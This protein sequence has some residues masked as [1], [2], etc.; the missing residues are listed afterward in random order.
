MRQSRG[1]SAAAML[2]V[3]LFGLPAAVSAQDVEGSR[4]HPL[5]NR[6]PD[7]FIDDYREKDFDVYDGFVDSDGSYKA[8]EGH[9]YYTDYHFKEGTKPLTEGFIIRNYREALKKIGGV[10]LYEDAYNAYMRLDKGGKMTWVHVHPWNGGQG[11]ALTIVEEAP[12]ERVVVADAAALFQEINATG[13]VAVCGIYFDTGKTL[14]KP[15]RPSPRGDRQA[16]RRP[17]R[18]QALSGRPHGQRGALDYNMNLSQKR[19]EAVVEVLV[20]RYSIA[21]A[22]WKPT[23]WAR[24]CRPPRTAPRMA[25]P[26]TGGSSWWSDEAA[27]HRSPC[28][29]YKVDRRQQPLVAGLQRDSWQALVFEVHR[30]A[31]LRPLTIRRR[32]PFA[33]E[34]NERPPGRRRPHPGSP[35]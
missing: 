3:L 29:A 15:D 9:K 26:R 16:P 6:L 27:D 24:C 10:V 19:A 31:S 8:V 4:D 11:I 23:E 25:G 5:F 28:P 18:P 17:D 20:S 14:V 35:V 2:V 1:S 33:M 13:K 12:M 22:G 32:R 34:R 21:Q 30:R 7:Y